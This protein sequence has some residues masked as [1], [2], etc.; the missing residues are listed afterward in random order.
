MPLS[1]HWR[2]GYQKL[3]HAFSQGTGSLSKKKQKQIKLRP[4]RKKLLLFI[5]GTGV[6]TTQ[7]QTQGPRWYWGPC[8]AWQ[9]TWHP[10]EVQLQPKTST[11]TARCKFYL[12]HL[13]RCLLHI[14]TTWPGAE[15]TECRHQVTSQRT[16][17]TAELLSSWRTAGNTV[18]SHD[19]TMR[20]TDFLWESALEALKSPLMRAKPAEPWGDQPRRSHNSW[21]PCS[22]FRVQHTFVK[23]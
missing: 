10:A 20:H 15:D 21:R 14:C 9:P 7:N 3:L 18:R 11:G 17:Q 16:P 23:P 6:Y 22:T 13:L 19:F 12:S 8:T 1:P 5:Y 4:R 2:H